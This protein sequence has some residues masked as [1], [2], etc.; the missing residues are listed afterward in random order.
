MNSPRG[1]S[2]STLTDQPRH[3]YNG[4]Q[5]TVSLKITIIKR[6]NG[7]TKKCIGDACKKGFDNFLNQSRKVPKIRP[8]KKYTEST[9][10]RAKKPSTKSVTENTEGSPM[11]RTTPTRTCTGN[12]IPR[13]NTDASANK[14]QKTLLQES[15]SV[16]F[17]PTPGLD[18]TF[19]VKVP[20]KPPFLVEST[21]QSDSNQTTSSLPAIVFNVQH[22]VNIPSPAKPLVKATSAEALTEV[23]LQNQ[24]DKLKPV[25]VQHALKGS[26]SS[27]LTSA[28]PQS[29]GL[30]GQ[31]QSTGTTVMVP[32]TATVPSRGYATVTNNAWDPNTLDPQ[33]PVNNPAIILANGYVIHH[34]EIRRNCCDLPGCTGV[35]CVGLCG[36]LKGSKAVGHLTHGY[37]NIPVTQGQ[38]VNLDANDDT[39]KSQEPQNAVM[40]NKAHSAG[41]TAVDHQGT[42]FLNQPHV[43][44]VIDKYADKS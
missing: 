29:L 19:E 13:G 18:K 7:G 40:Y 27:P 32:Q 34:N 36:N 5:L 35:I 26:N 15:S 41:P 21:T 42:S 12:I 44:P 39:K 6:F 4:T 30:F 23:C 33:A 22:T 8:A 17:K 14:G 11:V 24:T 38:V 10:P 37:P 3:L 9:S 25:I 2:Y 43:L 31:K 1:R 20:L 28:T 16:G